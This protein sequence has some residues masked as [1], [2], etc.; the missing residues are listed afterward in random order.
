MRKLVTCAAVVS[1]SECAATPPGAGAAEVP[2]GRA[3]AYQKKP[4]GGD[5]GTVLITSDSSFFGAGNVATVSI[6]R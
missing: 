2:P 3:M 6:D 5:Y 1:L 4:Q